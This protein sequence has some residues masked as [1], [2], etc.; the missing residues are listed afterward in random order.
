MPCDTGPVPQ[1]DENLSFCETDDTPPCNHAT[2]QHAHNTRSSMVEGGVPSIIS[3]KRQ[4]NW[5]SFVSDYNQIK[6]YF[7]GLIPRLYADVSCSQNN[8]VEWYNVHIAISS[9][10]AKHTIK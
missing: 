7:S 10:T 4:I 3:I 6:L 8:S 9:V 2:N 1:D 5:S